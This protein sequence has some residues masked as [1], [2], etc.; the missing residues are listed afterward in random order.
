MIGAVAA[1]TLPAAAVASAVTIV[2]PAEGSSGLAAG[3]PFVVSASVSSDA[4]AVAFSASGCTFSP[5]SVPG[6]PAGSTISVSANCNAG[7]AKATVA[8]KATLTGGTSSAASRTVTFDNAGATTPVE[9]T[10]E[11]SATPLCTGKGAFVAHAETADGLPVMG[12]TVTGTSAGTP[13]T[14][15]TNDDGDATLTVPLGDGTTLSGTSA[16]LAPYGA[17]T[18]ASSVSS[19]LD[20]CAIRVTVDASP[21]ASVTYLAPVTVSGHV[22]LERTTDLARMPLP[23]QSVAVTIGGAKFGSGKTN[24]AGEWSVT[25]PAP[26]SGQWTA[27][28]TTKSAFVAQKSDT[29]VGGTTTLVKY[30]G[31]LTASAPTTPKVGY[32]VAGNTAKLTA[33][34]DAKNP[35]TNTPSDPVSKGVVIRGTFVINGQSGGMLFGTKLK[36]GGAGQ[37]K[38]S[39]L[40]GGNG[41]ISL[42]A[43]PDVPGVGSPTATVPVSAQ[44]RVRLN[45]PGKSLPAGSTAAVFVTAFPLA[46]GQAHLQLSDDD[47][48]TWTTFADVPV[49]T[50]TSVTVPATPGMYSLRAL[51]DGSAIADAGSSKPQALTVTDPAKVSAA[52][53]TDLSCTSTNSENPV[54]IWGDPVTAAGQ[55]VTGIEVKAG[56]ASV[57]TLPATARTVTIPTTVVVGDKTVTVVKPGTATKVTLLPVV[58]TGKALASTA[59]PATVI[60]PVSGGSMRVTGTTTQVSWSS[61]KAADEGYFVSVDGGLPRL[62]LTNGYVFE[63]LSPATHTFTVTARNQYGDTSQP[64]QISLS[65]TADVAGAPAALSATARNGAVDLAWSAPADDGGAPVTDYVVEYRSEGGEWQTVADGVS[66]ATEATVPGLTNGLAYEFRV[67]AVNVIGT[68]DYSP[69]EPATPFTVPDAP[70]AVVAQSGVA[71]VSLSWSAPSFDGGAAVSS[72]HVYR[73]DNTSSVWSLV[74]SPS[75]LNFVDAS[76]PIGESSNYRISAVNAAGEST[77]ASASGA[78]YTELA[79][80]YP[81]TEFAR[82]QA[83]QQLAPAVTGANGTVAYAVTGTLPTGVTFSTSTGKFTG[84]NLTDVVPGTLN[85]AMSTKYATGT[86]GPISQAVPLSDGSILVGGTFSTWAGAAVGRMVKLNPDGSRNTVF[87]TNMGFGSNGNVND[88]LVQ[89]SGKII[90]ATSGTTW[91]GSPSHYIV[92]LNADGSRDT[93]FDANIGTGPND[94]VRQVIAY[95]DGSLLVRGDFSSWN[96][97]SGGA[98]AHLSAD[99]VLD[100]T[101]AANMPALNAFSLDMALLPSG[102]IL[103]SGTATSWKSVAYKYVL[104]LNA[105]GTRDTAFDAAVGS[106]ADGNVNRVAAQPDGKVILSGVFTKWNGVTVGGLVRL[107]ADG[108]RDTSFSANT[109]TGGN[110]TFAFVSEVDSAGR[111]FVGGNFTTWNGAA[112]QGFVVLDSSGVV[113]TSFIAGF[114][115]GSVSAMVPMSNNRLVVWGTFSAWQGVNSSNFA[116]VADSGPVPTPG[117]PAS[118]SVTA[119]D[120][121]SGQTVTV[122]VTLTVAAP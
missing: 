51:V 38:V 57:V 107:N 5:A 96:G 53:I 45:M 119:T 21:A 84:P 40:V 81:T 95:P 15:K 98:L 108:T 69:V 3:V 1:P 30:L 10:L 92:R 71:S 14:A 65:A 20:A 27:T 122:P 19:S 13:F 72:Y 43:D 18:T 9:L 118:V 60:A 79:V 4:D 28:A 12:L 74:A 101:F 42:Q 63:G 100:T 97:V 47:G 58:D 93:T 56:T 73:Q 88:V 35:D 85:S 41:A 113:D 77:F 121:T 67:A 54:C 33:D 31:T 50:E 87:A 44:A 39:G 37:L 64:L 36:T 16:A 25:G 89:P 114:G 76:A 116:V 59:V 94:I 22:Y 17:A 66:P 86:N 49:N 104:R 7:L 29:A 99:G 111:I 91:S 120:A 61:L 75:T 90:V 82:H 112:R 110:G 102:K 2:S 70:L 83:S 68:S 48:A 52:T 105:D 46:S 117:F 103:F 6:V 62:S 11:R 32:F 78:R 34:L 24:E 109:G 55:T 80:T 23:S 106:S 115:S 8:V 26:A